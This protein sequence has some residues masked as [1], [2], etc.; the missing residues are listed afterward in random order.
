[1]VW[2]LLACFAPADLDDDALRR[3]R[4]LHER[5]YDVYRLPRDPDQVHALL[6]GSLAGEALT[7]AYVEHWTT[8]ARMEAE[9]TQVVVEDVA[10]ESVEA[11]DH[12]RLSAA[13]RLTARVTHQGHEHVRVN[14]YQ[15]V[16]AY[17]DRKIT[18]SWIRNAERLPGEV[19]VETDDRVPLDQLLERL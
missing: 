11:L 13:W 1:M 18:G 16:F 6:S 15:A 3:F 4:G 19:P 10:W 2:L 5:V 7:D 14:R 12:E 17:R 8:L 9:D